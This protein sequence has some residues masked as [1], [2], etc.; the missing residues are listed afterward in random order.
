M[1]MSTDEVN[2]ASLAPSANPSCF[3]N[4]KGMLELVGIYNNDPKELNINYRK[5]ALKYH[6]D[7]GNGE[8]DFFS[9]VTN[10][11]RMCGEY[12]EK[13]QQG[14]SGPAMIGFEAIEFQSIKE[15]D[16][17]SYIDEFGQQVYGIVTQLHPSW[18]LEKTHI[19]M[20]RMSAKWE[21]DVQAKRQYVTK[22]AMKNIQ[23][24]KNEMSSCE[25]RSTSPNRA[26]GASAAPG[27]SGACGIPAYFEQVG[28]RELHP[29]D[30][31]HVQY[32]NLKSPKSIQ[33]AFGIFKGAPT[34]SECV[35]FVKTDEN[36]TPLS[37]A[38]T[39]VPLTGS[40]CQFRRLLVESS[41]KRKL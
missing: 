7:K 13:Y 10:C 22:E 6:P 12:L 11:V 35:E 29:G 40:G 37:K 24:L 8:K 9:L 23:R 3:L 18:G 32:V 28:W 5:W 26:T 41:K 27:R 38:V 14:H 16:R 36:F 15:G 4:C 39:I 31:I 1:N 34:Y 21:P 19:V 33:S 20:G 17:I 25:T 2:A 30:K